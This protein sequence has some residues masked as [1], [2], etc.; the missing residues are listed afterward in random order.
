M[1][2]GGGRKGRVELDNGSAKG[3]EVKGREWNGMEGE[4]QT[5]RRIVRISLSQN[6]R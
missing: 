4:L 6:Q 3:S 2:L 1:R 5:I